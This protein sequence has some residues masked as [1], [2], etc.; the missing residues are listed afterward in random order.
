MLIELS[1]P[2]WLRYVGLEWSTGSGHFPA[3]AQRPVQS[4]Q[5]RGHRDL[6]LREQI[7][8]VVKLPFRVEDRQK[9]RETRAIS[10][11][12]QL[13][14]RLVS[15]DGFL[16]MV[17]SPLLEGVVGQGILCFQQRPQYCRAVAELSLRKARV[18]QRDFGTNPTASEYRQS[19]G[20]AHGEEVPQRK[21]Q[22]VQLGRLPS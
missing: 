1:L 14:R 4:D 15:G 7:F 5:V 22:V 16:K 18:L 19:D 9:V 11:P 6:T 21:A 20:W 13:N 17:A 8:A 2:S 3:A 12:R 10:L